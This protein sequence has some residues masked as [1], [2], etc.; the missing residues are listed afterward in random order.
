[1]DSFDWEYMCVHASGARDPNHLGRDVQRDHLPSQSREVKSV[2]PGA[3]SDVENA[4]APP[5]QRIEVAPGRVSLHS[6]GP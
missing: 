4:I 5:D 1:M 6:A 2:F 3:T